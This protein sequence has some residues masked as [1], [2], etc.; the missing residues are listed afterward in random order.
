M[1]LYLAFGPLVLNLNTVRDKN[2]RSFDPYSN[3]L[4]I[5]CRNYIVPI[6]L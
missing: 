1:E 3:G 4:H 5:M 6:L 2:R